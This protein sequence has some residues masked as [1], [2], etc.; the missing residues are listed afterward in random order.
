MSSLEYIGFSPVHRIRIGQ[1]VNHIAIRFTPYLYSTKLIKLLFLI[2]EGSVKRYGVPI[3]WLEY[4]VYDKGPLPK[5]MWLNV[6]NDTNDLEDF[7]KIHYND[8]GY[9]ILPNKEHQLTEFS[10][11][12]IQIIKD[13]LD[14]FGNLSADQLIKITHRKYGLWSKMVKEKKIQFKES[15]ASPYIID[16]CDLIREDKIKMMRYKNAAEEINALESIY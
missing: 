15:D 16:F 12:E 6:V 8:L 14:K 11:F 4:N 7:I 2:D 10:D 1:L 3:T 5:K 9:Q 13:V